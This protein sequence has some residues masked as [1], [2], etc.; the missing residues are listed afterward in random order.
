M[1]VSPNKAAPPTDDTGAEADLESARRVL[2]LEKEGLEALARSLGER[3]VAALDIL[4]G[5]KGRVVVAGHRQEWPCRPQ[6][7]RDLGLDRDAGTIRAPGRGE[8]RRT[9]A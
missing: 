8:P 7:R 9:L 3:F 5:V 2:R 4:G 6:D 1:N